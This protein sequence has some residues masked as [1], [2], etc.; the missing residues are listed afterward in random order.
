MDLEDLLAALDVR[1]IHHHTAVEAARPQQRR[2]EDVRPVGGGDDNDVGVGIEPVHLDQHLVQR[3]LALVV[4]AAQAGAAM[5]AHCVDLVHEN[6]A[7]RVALGLIEQVAHAAGADA[8]EHLDELRAG[9]GEER[10]ASLARD[11]LGHQG[12]AGA[13]RADQQHA[14]R[15]ARAQGREFLRFLEELDHFLELFFRLIGAGHVVKGHGRLVAGEHARFALA[16]GKGLVAGALGLA[17]DEKE[18]RADEDDRKEGAQ[19][20]RPILPPAARRKFQLHAGFLLVGHSQGV[21]RLDQLG[22]RFDARAD[23]GCISTGSP[24]RL[25]LTRRLSRRSLRSCPL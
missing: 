10:H 1:L 18:E 2:V 20:G 4:A 7:R 19:D 14:L 8:H 21:E 11:G 3:L 16:E 23:L 12:L 25:R 17:E 6:D 22:V 15:D 5:A 24:Y 9:D 13:R